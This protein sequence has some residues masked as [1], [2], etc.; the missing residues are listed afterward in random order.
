MT[1]NEIIEK[2]YQDESSQDIAEFLDVETAE[3]ALR[4]KH[5]EE[6]LESVGC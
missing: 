6:M 1:I 2:P 4:I 3:I 5:M